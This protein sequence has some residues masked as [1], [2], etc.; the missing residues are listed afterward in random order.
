MT[1]TGCSALDGHSAITPTGGQVTVVPSF[2]TFMIDVSKSKGKVVNIALIVALAAIRVFAQKPP[3]RVAPTPEESSLGV[4]GA[5]LV[6]FVL[7][8]IGIA[9]IFYLRKRE[10]ANNDPKTLG[11]NGSTS[12]KPGEIKM[13]YRPKAKM[14]RMR[15]RAFESAESDET[16][17]ITEVVKEIPNAGISKLPISSFVRL[18]HAKTFNQLP[19]SYDEDLLCAI[20]QTGEGSEE[21]VEIRTLALKILAV[22]KNSNSVKA[23][24]QIALYD[25]SSKLRST[26]VSVLAGTDHE[27]VFEPIV[28]ACAD[29]TREVRAAAARSLFRLK[30]DRA[31][32]WTRIIE[33]N[34]EGR[35]RQAARAAM[36]GDLVDRSFERLIHRDRNIAY[37]AYALTALLIKAGEKE[38]IYRALA[39]HKDENVKLALLHVLQTIKTDKTFQD[40][41]E[42]LIRHELTPNVA[43][44]VNEVRSYS[45]M[46]HV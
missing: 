17:E 2:Q 46:M 34:N 42:L 35:M 5:Y 15:L 1:K 27:S 6:I 9:A 20:E 16:V 26:A 24:A 33:S 12:L 23:I 37:E 11:K 32:A 18:E 30:I 8:G 31:H 14:R 25:L 21:D 4:Y 13:T 45:Q 36:E 40:L 41:S 10:A 38:P 39:E 29:P 43:A 22:F 28:L 3:A 44:K 7:V 19:E